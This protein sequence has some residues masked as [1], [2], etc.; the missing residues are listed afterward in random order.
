MSLS[1]S[2]VSS[3][4]SPQRPQRKHLEVWPRSLQ[5]NGSPRA[6][7]KGSLWEDSALCLQRLHGFPSITV[8][9]P[10][11]ERDRLYLAESVCLWQNTE[12][13]GNRITCF[14]MPHHHS[15]MTVTETLDQSTIV[16]FHNKISNWAVQSVVNTSSSCPQTVPVSE[17]RASLF[18]LLSSFTGG[19]QSPCT[20]RKV[21]GLS[22][23]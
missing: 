2:N 12:L 23:G 19:S 7:S 11:T 16:F 4:P 6:L 18:L 9:Q 20:T 17:A 10:E 3:S 13:N 21:L 1:S 15:F 5:D 22:W 8:A 14:Q